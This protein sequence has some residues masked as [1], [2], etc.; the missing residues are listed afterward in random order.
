[1]YKELLRN[2]V[3]DTQFQIECL[4]EELVEMLM[5]RYGWDMKKALDE[6]GFCFFPYTASGKE[7]L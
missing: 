1:M 3:T 4:S 2:Q 7:H 6:L 5:R